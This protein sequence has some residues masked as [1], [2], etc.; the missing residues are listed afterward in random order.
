[1]SEISTEQLISDTIHF[2]S[3]LSNAS[4]NYLDSKENLQELQSSQAS[5]KLMITLGVLKHLNRHI[6]KEINRS[7]LVSNNE[8]LIVESQQ[9]EIQNL[10]Y[11][12][13]H[14]CKDIDDSNNSYNLSLETLELIP[15]DRFLA[16]YPNFSDLPT[17]SH[18]L[19][20]ERLKDEQK[21]R[22]KLLLRKNHLLEIKSR[23]LAENRQR[24]AKL[25]TLEKDFTSFNKVSHSDS[26]GVNKLLI[27]TCV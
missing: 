2:L 3:N 9:S 16:K 15:L 5:K 14:L 21:E 27:I 26:V 18:Q 10:N 22:L 25:D 13:K 12:N 17:N 24:K 11:Q 8:K 4:K 1:M 23:I 19:L 6:Q 20:L 7:K